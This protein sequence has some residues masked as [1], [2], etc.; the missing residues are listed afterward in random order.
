MFL[1]M[2]SKKKKKKTAE[3]LLLNL[4]KCENAWT[5]YSSITSC[6]LD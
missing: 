1:K 3:D 2:M 6:Q 5:G 4:V